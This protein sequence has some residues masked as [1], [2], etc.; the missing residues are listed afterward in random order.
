MQDK[1]TAVVFISDPMTGI[2]DYGRRAFAAAEAALRENGYEVI[3]NPAALPIGMPREKYLPI[4]IAMLEAA[5]TI[6]M[7][8]GWEYSGGARLEYD[9]ALYQGKTVL[10]EVDDQ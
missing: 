1:K 7:L 3:L 2:A 6:Y 10:R 5:D 4:T 9:Y 8:K